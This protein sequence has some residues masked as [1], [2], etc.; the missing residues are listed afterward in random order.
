M[1][2]LIEVL[3]WSLDWSAEVDKWGGVGGSLPPRYLDPPCYSPS[4]ITASPTQP[5]LSWTPLPEKIWLPYLRSFGSPTWKILVFAKKVPIPWLNFGDSPTQD[6]WV[7]LPDLKNFGS[8]TWKLFEFSAHSDSPS[9]I[10]GTPPLGISKLDSPAW[11]MLTPLV[12]NR[13]LP[14]KGQTPLAEFSFSG[15]CHLTP[16]PESEN[17]FQVQSDSPS[18]VFVTPP[19]KISEL[20]SLSWIILTPLPEKFFFA[21]KGPTPLVEFW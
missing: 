1:E 15:K 5:F 14:K 9:S 6:F 4:Q 19:F 16:L 17:F 12:E 21:K 10:L 20:N 3:T 2:Y 18:W 11:K 7:G 8:P 13:I